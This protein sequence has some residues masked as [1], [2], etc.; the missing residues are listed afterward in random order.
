MASLSG[1]QCVGT[2]LPC[3]TFLNK[4]RLRE[5]KLKKGVRNIPELGIIVG[6]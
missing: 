2:L 3:V 5:A 6:I 1:L 4:F